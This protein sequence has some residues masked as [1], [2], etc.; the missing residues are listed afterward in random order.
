MGLW[1]LVASEK[2]PSERCAKSITVT[3]H[4]TIPALAILN[5]QLVHCHRN[6]RTALPVKAAIPF[7]LLIIAI[8]VTV[9]LT[10]HASAIRN[11]QLVHCHR[12]SI[13]AV[14]R[15]TAGLFFA[16]PGFLALLYGLH[17]IWCASTARAGALFRTCIYAG[18]NIA[19]DSP[20]RRQS[21]REPVNKQRGQKGK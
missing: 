19:I 3:V 14:R 9:H 2:L 16:L 4:L 6:S 15:L 7:K 12:N 18:I 1:P 20:R 5:V 17:T 8:T 10:I 11:V 21:N 13:E